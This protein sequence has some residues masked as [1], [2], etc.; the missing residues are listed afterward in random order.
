[1]RHNENCQRSVK[2]KNDGTSLFV[3]SRNKATAVVPEV[4]KQ[5][6]ARSPGK[7]NPYLMNSIAHIL[8][9]YMDYA[10][11]NQNYAGDINYLIVSDTIKYMWLKNDQT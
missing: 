4:L 10:I 9:Q 6:D 7:L 1:M 8:F 11:Q 3:V 5:R 2:L